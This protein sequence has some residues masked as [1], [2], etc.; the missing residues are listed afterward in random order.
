LFW[1]NNNI[2]P[3]QPSDELRKIRSRENISKMI[4][5]YGVRI[6]KHEHIL[7]EL[8]SEEYKDAIPQYRIVQNGHHYDFYSGNILWELDEPKHN[9]HKQKTLDMKYDLQAKELGYEVRR[10]WLKDIH[11][12]GLT[13]WHN[14]QN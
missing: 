14:Y 5:K 2:K 13:I 1:D 7:F 4:E 11:K 12:T 9:S 3:R 6:G 8:L 10:I